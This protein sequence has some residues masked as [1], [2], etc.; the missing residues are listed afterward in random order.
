MV[1]YRSSTLPLQVSDDTI[2][3]CIDKEAAN[4]VAF[5]TKSFCVP[6]VFPGLFFAPASFAAQSVTQPER[7]HGPG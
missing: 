6:I 1:E 4:G 2:L 7:Q 5:D 3:H